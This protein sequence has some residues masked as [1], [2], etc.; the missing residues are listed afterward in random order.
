[1]NALYGA[2]YIGVFFY[3]TKHFILKVVELTVEPVWNIICI[4]SQLKEI[5]IGKNRSSTGGTNVQTIRNN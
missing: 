1:M 5:V 3:F 4:C 2:L